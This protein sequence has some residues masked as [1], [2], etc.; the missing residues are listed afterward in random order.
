MKPKSA[1][2]VSFMT[3]C[4]IVCNLLKLKGESSVH[5]RLFFQHRAHCDSE[6]RSRPNISGTYAF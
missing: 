2:K 4:K 1:T 5:K 3:V 6:T